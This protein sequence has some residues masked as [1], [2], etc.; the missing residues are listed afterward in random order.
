MKKM[1]VT[2]ATAATMLA[3]AAY[4]DVSLTSSNM[5]EVTAGSRYHAGRAPRGNSFR[6]DVRVHKN[7]DIYSTIDSVVWLSGNAATAEAN[8]NAHGYNTFS[9][10]FTAAVT[11]PFSSSSASASIAGTD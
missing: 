4:A 11:T 9:E 5:D 1:I 2:A 8:A 10:T 3:G 6:L 7:I